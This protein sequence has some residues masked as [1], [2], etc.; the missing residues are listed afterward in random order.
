M[1]QRTRRILYTR[2][3]RDLRAHSSVFPLFIRLFHRLP[4]KEQVLQAGADDDTLSVHIVHQAVG[5][6][7]E[8]ILFRAC[9]L[10]VW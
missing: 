3:H 7:E 2:A 10:R 5:E 8:V 4:L 1:F 6:E 9:A